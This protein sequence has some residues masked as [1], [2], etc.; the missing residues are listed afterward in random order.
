MINIDSTMRTVRGVNGA[1]EATTDGDN[2]N[3]DND[4][5]GGGDGW[6]QGT[7]RFVAL[8][9][10]VSCCVGLCGAFLRRVLAPHRVL[11]RPSAWLTPHV[12]G[13]ATSLAR[14]AGQPRR[15]HPAGAR[16]PGELGAVPDGWLLRAAR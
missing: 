1:N 15:P 5:D 9:R 4:G 13:N 16:S 10:A 2:D 3:D 6:A 7:F 12:A 8:G 14:P 11:A